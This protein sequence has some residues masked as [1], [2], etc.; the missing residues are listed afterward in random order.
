LVLKAEL[1]DRTLSDKQVSNIAGKLAKHAGQSYDIIP[2]WDSPESVGIANR[3][4]LALQSG[5]HW[6]YTPP[7]RFTEIVGGVVGIIVSV[8]PKADEFTQQG[9]EDLTLALKAEGLEAK[10]EK[11]NPN[12]PIE[13]MIHLTVG[14]KR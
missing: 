1:A 7:G 2:Y 11:E 13:N 8:H 12:N 10:E 9:A 14:S 5:A 3:I 4:Q 6:T